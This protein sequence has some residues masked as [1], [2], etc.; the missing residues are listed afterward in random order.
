MEK[1]SHTQFVLDIETPTMQI[2]DH[3][4]VEDDTLLGEPS[5]D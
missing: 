3:S 4:Q 5:A 1:P 2:E